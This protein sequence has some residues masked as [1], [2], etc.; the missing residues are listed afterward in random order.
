MYIYIY[1][2]KREKE[3]MEMLLLFCFWLG[4]TPEM[5]ERKIEREDGRKEE[6]EG[7]EY[8]VVL[9]LSLSLSL[10]SA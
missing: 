7:V 1:K 5:K 3:K 4:V 9:S 10:K 2:M 8:W 6:K